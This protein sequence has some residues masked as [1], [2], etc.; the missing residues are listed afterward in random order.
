MSSVKLAIDHAYTRP[1]RSIDA[2]V[3]GTLLS[4]LFKFE[5]RLDAKRPLRLFGTLR[6]EVNRCE[7]LVTE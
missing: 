1:C 3:R 4:E 5:T 6:R 2:A 7:L